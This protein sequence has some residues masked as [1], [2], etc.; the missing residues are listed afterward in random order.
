MDF[1][2]TLSSSY[3]DSSPLAFK[4]LYWADWNIIR[5]FSSAVKTLCFESQGVKKTWL[6]HSSQLHC[7]RPHIC[8]VVILLMYVLVCFLFVKVKIFNQTWSIICQKVNFKS[9]NLFI[10]SVSVSCCQFLHT[11][12][13]QWWSFNYLFLMLL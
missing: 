8:F 4:Q 7:L 10:A 1:M 11:F 13:F 6:H 9:N 3:F 2:V 5:T 12:K